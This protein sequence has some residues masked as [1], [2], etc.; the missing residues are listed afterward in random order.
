MDFAGI[1][2]YLPLKPILYSPQ[3]SACTSVGFGTL[4]G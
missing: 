3:P 2:N 4:E 1:Y